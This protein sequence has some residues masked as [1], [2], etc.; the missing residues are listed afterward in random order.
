MKRDCSRLAQ[1]IRKHSACQ[2][3]SSDKRAAPGSASRGPS[4]P[5]PS[6]RW[7][8]LGVCPRLRDQAEFDWDRRPVL[9]QN[10]IPNFPACHRRQ[11]QSRDKPRDKPRGQIVERCEA[12][13][14]NHYRQNNYCGREGGPIRR[15]ALQGSLRQISFPQLKNQLSPARQQKP[16]QLRRSPDISHIRCRGPRISL[17]HQTDLD[18]V[19]S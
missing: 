18:S 15:L 8:Q 16:M 6:R 13:A 4:W 1:T 5:E 14:K 19:R 12:I 10:R 11:D 7:N 9:H 3:R 2:S 17:A